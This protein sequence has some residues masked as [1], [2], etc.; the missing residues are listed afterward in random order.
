MSKIAL[1]GNASGTGTFT[2]ASPNSNTDR[3]LTLPDATGTILT[4]A[5]PGV[6]VNGPAFSAYRTAD[7]TVTNNT[8]TKVQLNIEE[9][10]TNNCFDST[11]NYRFTPN[12]AGYYQVNFSIYGKSSANDLTLNTARIVK[13]GADLAYGF[14]GQGA[15]IYIPSRSYVDGAAVGSTLVYMNGSTDYI[16]LYARIVA[17]GTIAVGSAYFQAFLA[18][19]AT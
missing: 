11:T 10:D 17:S 18:R 16:E 6:P 1:S 2:V 15:Y 4:T 13:N 19:S 7:Q 12:V 8:A 5:T 9:Y 3:T 14:S